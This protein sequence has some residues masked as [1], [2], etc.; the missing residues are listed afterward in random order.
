[1]KDW[2]K[3]PTWEALGPKLA[4]I[5]ETEAGCVPGLGAVHE[6]L[7]GQTGPPGGWLGS[8]TTASTRKG[9]QFGGPLAAFVLLGRLF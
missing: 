4:A 9:P 3:E 8:T 7:R 6:R 1:M 5:F 2:E